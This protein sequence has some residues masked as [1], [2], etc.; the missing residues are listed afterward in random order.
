MRPDVTLDFQ[1]G[2]VDGRA[3][4]SCELCAFMILLLVESLLERGSA[5]LSKTIRAFS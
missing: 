4:H 1:L 2:Q 5:M 3:A